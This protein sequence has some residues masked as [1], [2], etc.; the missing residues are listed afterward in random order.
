MASA[1]ADSFVVKILQTFGLI[2]TGAIDGHDGVAQFQKNPAAYDLVLLDMFMP[3][4]NGEPSLVALRAIKP[5]VR[6][7]LMSGYTEGDVLRRLGGAG[8][9]AFIAKPFTR[10]ALERKLR[11]LLD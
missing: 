2:A 6:V 11:E 7:L 9:L 5:D 4:M 3:G 1:S 10:T 8:R